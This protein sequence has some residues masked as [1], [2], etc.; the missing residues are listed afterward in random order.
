MIT[1]GKREV[2]SDIATTP[3]AIR[4]TFAEHQEELR[5][6]AGFLTGD[7]EVAQACVVD[8]CAF[9]QRSW[10]G[11][12]DWFAVSPA[13]ATVYS[14]MQIQRSRIAELS[15]V[16]EGRIGG[17][18]TDEQLPPDL[19]ELIVTESD[20]IRSRLDTICRFVLVICGIEECPSTEAARWLG[21][22]WPAVEAAYCAA[23]ESLEG[24]DCE[25]QIESDA[26]PAAWN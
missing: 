21:I 14:A 13:F 2:L 3:E 17:R 15:P 19:L 18:R 24:F 5:W 16:Y 20:V 9:A 7:D 8:A 26:A 6:L 12:A 10:E 1:G 23:L 4:G 22:S 25:G 11:G